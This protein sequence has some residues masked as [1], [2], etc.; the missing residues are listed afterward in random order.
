MIDKIFH[1]ADIHIRNFKRHGEYREVFNKMYQYLRENVTDN[2]LIYL[3]GDIVHSKNDMSPELVQ[4]VTDLFIQCSEIA[5][6]V[7]I[8]GNH[9]ANLNN[10]SRLD[11]LTPIV[12]SIN[13]YTDRLMYWRDNG[14]YEYGGVKFSVHSVFNQPHEWISA[15]Q[16]DGDYKIALYHGAVFQSITDVGYTVQSDKVS[17][18]TFR[19]FDLTLLGDIHKLQYLDGKRTIAYPG[20][21]IQ[22]NHGEELKHGFLV[23]DLQTKKSEYVE[24]PNDYGYV[25]IDIDD[26]K[27]ITDRDYV[28]QFPEKLRM[29]IRYWNTEYHEVVRIMNILKKKY[30]VVEFNLSKQTS[31]DTSTMDRGSVLGNV[32]D[33]E[34]QNKLITDYLKGMPE[35]DSES[36]KRIQD[37]NRDM[38]SQLETEGVI[39][40][41][42]VWR[43]LK[44]SFSNMFSYGENNEIEFAKYNGFKGL[45]APNASGKSTLL[46]AVTFCLFDKCSRTYKGKDVLNNSKK[47]FHCDLVFELNEKNYRIRRFGKL[48]KDGNNVR[49]EV[50]FGVYDN[51]EYRSLNGKNRDDTNKIIRGYV[52]TY[53]DFLLTTLSTQNDNKNF[54]FKTQRER[55]DLL[56]SFLDISIFDDLSSLVRSEI[57]NRRAVITEMER[58]I[59]PEKNT[60]LASQLMEVREESERKTEEYETNLNIIERFNSRIIELHSQMVNLENTVNIEEVEETIEKYTNI[61][62]TIDGSIDGLDTDIRE[63]DMYLNSL[64]VDLAN[65]D[66]KKLKHE[67]RMSVHYLDELTGLHTKKQRIESELS[68]FEQQI[69]HLDTHEYNPECEYCV[70][71]TFVKSALEAKEMYPKLK[72]ELEELNGIIEEVANEQQLA[73][74][75]VKE[76]ET[77][78]DNLNSEHEKTEKKILDN[79]KDLESIKFKRLT[80]IDKLETANSNKE[81]YYKQI[82]QQQHN[83]KLKIELSELD[84]ELGLLRDNNKVVHS[85]MVKLNSELTKLETAYENY[86]NTVKRFEELSR[87]LSS[88]ELYSQAVS[89]NGV[90]HYLLAK[91]LPVIESEVNDILS[92][93]SEFYVTFEEDDKNINC[94]LHY[95]DTRSWP[96]ELASGMERFMVSIATRVALINVST[97]PRPNFIAIDEGFG[98]LDSDKLSSIG[99]L[100]EYLKEQFDFVLCIS[101][102]D[103]MKD[104]ADSLITISKNS[105]GYSQ[106]QDV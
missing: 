86:K 5:P 67:R 55:K 95:S 31:V 20:S 8:A 87:E 59:D 82:E 78:Y 100:F 44:F 70:N 19:G 13:K 51:G 22:Q 66:M 65:F 41:N 37:I 83:E 52:G 32:R 74:T 97:L 61:V 45:F 4:M 94:Y 24:I 29:R 9:D 40:R 25:T 68:S 93:L 1:I 12:E 99:I 69:K 50:E 92:Q 57:K 6:T 103:T 104:L 15:S 46:D 60:G 71:N 79:Q 21:L 77:I 23:W 72:T 10:D 36:S 39:V 63:L 43:P 2:S 48:S 62:E 54:I 53:N 49:V 81:L 28:M 16:I 56:N 33:V 18:D 27:I 90:P 38:N 106:I 105:E 3:A 7:V 35:F 101:H 73:V 80:A 64:S 75:K 98:V 34:Y 96:V 91:I 47:D 84:N 17:V 30:T 76:W 89:K 58:E 88:Y 42:M 14:V 102:L 11:A 85:D 26:G